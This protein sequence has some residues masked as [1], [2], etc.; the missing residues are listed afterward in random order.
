[1]EYTFLKL[2]ED[3]LEKTAKEDLVYS[4]PYREIWKQACHYGFSS[5]LK[6]EG[7]TPW[8]SL[9][10]QLYVD[11]R[12]NVSSIFEKVDEKPARFALKKYDEKAKSQIE[13]DDKKIHEDVLP[14][15]EIHFQEKDLHPLLV[16]YVS[17]KP[18]CCSTKTIDEKKA[19]SKYKGQNKWAYP[20]LIGV[21]YP[22]KDYRLEVIDLLKAY[23]SIPVK[24]YSFE[25]KR[26]INWGNL[27]E[28]YF[29]AVSNSS[30]ANE[31]Y[32]VAFEYD[33]TDVELKEEMRKLNNKYG[34]GFIKLETKVENCKI[35]FSSKIRESIDLDD[36][37]YLCAKNTDVRELLTNAKESINNKRSKAI[38]YDKILNDGELEKW[39]LDKKIK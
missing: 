6:S 16:K 15:A 30:W 1:M 24:F 21:Y 3:V 33:E 23:S 22:F 19:H 28:S 39:V 36:L 17:R 25:L 14:S 7:K 8:S 9:G 11:V 31:G 20:D 35:L 34:I 10:A 2:A 38:E 37:N 32:L 13:L 26:E 18:F 27:K 5:K 12:D 4:L 29:Q